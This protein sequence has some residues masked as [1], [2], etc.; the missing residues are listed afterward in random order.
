[1]LHEVIESKAYLHRGLRIVFRDGTSGETHTLKCDEGIREYLKKVVAERKRTPTVDF[2]FYH[3]RAEDPRME[4]ALQWT[5][6]TAEHIRSYANGIRTPEGGTHELGLKAGVVKA[7]RGYMESHN[8]QPKGVT[9]AAEDIR[10]G[11]TAVLSVYL[12]DPQF[13][14]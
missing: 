10:E 5:D 3:E 11:L 12:P 4:L 1:R 9:V 7:V 6:E 14:G 13:Q 2:T 8:L